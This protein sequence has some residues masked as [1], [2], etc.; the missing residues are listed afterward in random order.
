MKDFKLILYYKLKAEMSSEIPNKSIF[1]NLQVGSLNH[2]T[3]MSFTST[4][5]SLGKWA[6][7]FA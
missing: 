7:D 4:G 2:R 1:L 5:T 6:D 3:V